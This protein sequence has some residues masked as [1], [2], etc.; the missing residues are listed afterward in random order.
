[1]NHAQ[2]NGPWIM[3]QLIRIR[4]MEKEVKDLLANSEPPRAAVRSR[5]AELNSQL[6]LLDLALD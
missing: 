5:I 3:A 2:A 4:T 6:A 1:M